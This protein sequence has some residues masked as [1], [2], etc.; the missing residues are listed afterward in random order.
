MTAILGDLEGESVRPVIAVGSWRRSGKCRHRF[1]GRSISV[2]RQKLLDKSRVLDS[3]DVLAI[4]YDGAPISSAD[5]RLTCG[6]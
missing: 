3:D 2:A 6:V 5:Y 1:G 4:E